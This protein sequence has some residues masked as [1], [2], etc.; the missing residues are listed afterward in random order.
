MQQPLPFSQAAE[1]NKHVIAREIRP[2]LAECRSV[3][4]IG[5]GT[6]QHAVHFAGLFPHLVWQCGDQIAYH[7]GITQRIESS[8][9]PNMPPVIELE[10]RTF[11]W[12]DFDFDAVFTANTAHIMPWEAVETTIDGVSQVLPANGVLL[13][14]GPFNENREFTS[15]SNAEFDRYLKAQAGHMG[16]RDRGEMQSRAHQNGLELVSSAPMPANN[17]ILVFQKRS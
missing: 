8:Q 4:E 3:L 6:G 14:Y 12:A 5:S 2:W 11:N 9:L 10:A 15:E 16:I 17:Q 7:A 13:W 1:N